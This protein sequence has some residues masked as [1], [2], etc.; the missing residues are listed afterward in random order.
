MCNDESLGTMPCYIYKAI[1][2]IYLQYT[3]TNGCLSLGFKN[4][5]FAA[6]GKLQKEQLL[7]NWDN[8]SFRV[9]IN[10]QLWFPEDVALSI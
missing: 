4:S 8:L 10:T 6:K 1:V 7:T 2:I 5:V 9:N 3:F